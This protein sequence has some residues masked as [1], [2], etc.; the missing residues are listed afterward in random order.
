MLSEIEL[1]AIEAAMWLP[2]IYFLK[3]MQAHAEFCE[4]LIP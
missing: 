3:M 1:F 4:G 2:Y